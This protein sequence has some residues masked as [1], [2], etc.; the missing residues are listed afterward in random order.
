MLKNTVFPKW[1]VLLFVIQI[2]L[3]LNTPGVGV[4][5]SRTFILD[6]PLHL[7]APFTDDHSQP[8]GL[9]VEQQ[10]QSSLRHSIFL[11]GSELASVLTYYSRVPI[12]S[13]FQLFLQPPL[14][15]PPWPRSVNRSSP[16]LL[17]FANAF[18]PDNSFLYHLVSRC[19]RITTTPQ[20]PWQ[21]S[22]YSDFNL[23]NFSFFWHLLQ[24]TQPVSSSCY[25]PKMKL[26]Q[27]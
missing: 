21:G 4:P 2:T 11:R 6:R 18:K 27:I 25:E 5:P 26:L 3:M 24:L 14:W 15:S 23:N 1:A 12:S 22:R 13:Q 7:F 10:R 19:Y 16:L 8:P 20:L 17:Q 9:P